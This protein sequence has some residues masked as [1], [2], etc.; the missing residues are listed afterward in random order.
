MDNDG[1]VLL[2]TILP[3]VPLFTIDG[4]PRTVAATPRV[5]GRHVVSA[6][7][8]R[9]RLLTNSI[10]K[11]LWSRIVSLLTSGWL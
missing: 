9:I 3:V 8:Q 11:C 5:A 4:S 2:I 7:P 10:K 6:L 1:F